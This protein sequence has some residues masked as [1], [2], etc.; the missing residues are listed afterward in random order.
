MEVVEG[1]NLLKTDHLD[2]RTSEITV[3]ITPTISLNSKRSCKKRTER[4][5][6]KAGYIAANGPITDSFSDFKA[7][8]KSIVPTPQ[9]KPIIRA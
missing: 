7:A 9:H 6:V 1:D 4:M 3:N 2:S 5:T 8:I